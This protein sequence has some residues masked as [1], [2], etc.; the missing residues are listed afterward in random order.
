[1]TRL[2]KE[3]DFFAPEVLSCPFA[4]DA[5]ARKEQPVLK[6]TSQENTY[7]VFSYDLVK[8][9]LK[10]PN[11]Y[12][13]KNEQALLGRSVYDESCKAIYKQGW[14]QVPTL[15]TND[16]PEHTRFR[17]LVQRAFMP[18]RIDRLEPFINGVADQL[19]DSFI[20]DG[21]CDFLEQFA[22][23]YPCTIIANQL[24]VPISD[25]SKVATW[26]TAFLELIGSFLPPEEEQERARLVVEYQHYMKALLDERRINPQDDM[27]TDLLNARVDDER[28]LDETELLAVSQQLLVAGNGTTTHT[29]GAGLWMMIERPELLAQVRERPELVDKLVEEVI[30]V[31]TPT[32]SMWRRAT[33]KSLLGG[34]EVPQGAMLLLRYGSAN[35]DEKYFESADVI[36]LQRKYGAPSMAFGAGTHSCIGGVLARKELRCAFLRLSQRMTNIRLADGA[37]APEYIPNVLLRGIDGL[38]IK[39]DKIA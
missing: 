1:M 17:K 9:V 25:I 14:A 18:A 28:P 30:R 11:L 36:D 34:V 29:I 13:S 21:H 15:L 27:L 38:Q 4:F 5:E 31:L 19:I 8:Q 3:Q 32:N 7:I 2:I 6:S 37:K 35:R 23:P 24:G 39:F 10:Q 20:D 12:S 33:E 26:S 16:P 22:G